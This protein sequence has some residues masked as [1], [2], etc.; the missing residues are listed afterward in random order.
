MIYFRTRELSRAVMNTVVDKGNKWSPD[1]QRTVDDLMRDAHQCIGQLL[2]AG[3]AMCGRAAQSL[4]GTLQEKLACPITEDMEESS[5]AGE[6]IV[7]N[8]SLMTVF[9]IKVCTIS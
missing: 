8:V 3:G 7:E 9:A 1:E 4:W 2:V 6:R 5:Q